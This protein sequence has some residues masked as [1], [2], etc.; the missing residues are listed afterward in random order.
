[1]DLMP[2]G[3]TWSCIH[4]QGKAKSHFLGNALASYI[5]RAVILT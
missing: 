3:I 1:M 5:Y 2:F 4:G